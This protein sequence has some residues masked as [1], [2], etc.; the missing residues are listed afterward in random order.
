METKTETPGRRLPVFTRAREE[1]L[2]ARVPLTRLCVETGIP[3]VYLSGYERGL[4]K[5]TP[6]QVLARRDAIRRLKGR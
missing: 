4:H 2:R 1:R 5:L 6:E 3:L